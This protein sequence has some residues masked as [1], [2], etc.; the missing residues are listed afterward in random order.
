[1][2]GAKG[3]FWN[4]LT[5]ALVVTTL[6]VVT[7][8]PVLSGQAFDVRGVTRDTVLGNGLHVITAR[9]SSL[10]L[11]TIEIVVRGGALAQIEPEDE[12]LPHIL[13]HMLFKSFDRS[14]RDWWAERTSEMNAAYNGTTGDERVTY[15][16]TLPSD[17]VDDGLELLGDGDP[18]QVPRDAMVP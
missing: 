9:N 10:P 12:G 8:G 11:A 17:N 4:G 1:M 7:Y 16:L 14:G 15:Y 6:A 18:E 2:L 3:R 13:E 5:R